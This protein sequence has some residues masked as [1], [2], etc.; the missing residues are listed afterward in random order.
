MVL[1]EAMSLPPAKP[2]GMLEEKQQKALISLLCD[3]DAHIYRTVRQKIIS[4]GPASA[5][6]MREYALSSDPVLR[7]R[8]NEIVQHF[9]RLA[10]DTELLAFCLNQGE[11]FDLERGVMLL[12]RTQYPDINIEAYGA[13]L[14]DYARDLRERLDL[15]GEAGEVLRG[16]NDYLFR[17]QKFLGEEKNAQGPEDSYF[18]RVI[19]RKAGNPVSLCILYLLVGR[20]LRLPMAGIGLPQNYFLCRYQTSRAEVYIDAFN[21]GRLLSKS[22]CIKYVVQLRQ[23]FEDSCLAP[24]SSRRILLRICANL[25][26]IYTQRKA[27]EQ[28]ERLQSYL[29]ALAK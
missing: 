15:N 24:M 12:A 20:R 18:S 13:I 22:D 19:D 21:G 27:P 29:V 7:R 5:R 9:A 2:A 6:W 1:V 8:A 17:T 14:D 23:R 16:I 10:A 4:F 28:M 25:H 26:Q 11:D 3:D